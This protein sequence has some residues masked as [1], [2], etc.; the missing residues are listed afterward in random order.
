MVCTEQV[1]CEF[2]G[3]S[4]WSFGTA[5]MP[6]SVMYWSHTRVYHGAAAR[7]EV[8]KTSAQARD[9]TELLNNGKP[10]H[11]ARKQMAT[12]WGPPS[13]GDRRV[14]I[15]SYTGRVLAHVWVVHCTVAN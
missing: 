8:L 12:R 11:P 5:Q 10:V 4:N 3:Y 6:L 7:R 2:P 13:P 9:L 15:R 1:R 14:R